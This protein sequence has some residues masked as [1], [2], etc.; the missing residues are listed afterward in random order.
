MWRRRLGYS[1]L[2][3]FVSHYAVALAFECSENLVACGGR[4]LAIA[5]V[6][7]FMLVF[8]FPG[9]SIPLMCFFLPSIFCYIKYGERLYLVWFIAMCLMSGLMSYLSFGR[10]MSV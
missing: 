3:L 4:S 9:M 2:A 5:M 1:L 6:G 7:F 8:E 10:V